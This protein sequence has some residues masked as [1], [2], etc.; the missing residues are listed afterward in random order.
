MDA[1]GGANQKR[2]FWSRIAPAITLMV[3]APLCAEVL[4]GATRFSSIFVF[5]IE[6]LVWGGGAVMIR[7]LVRANRLGWPSMVMLALCLALAEEFL[8]Q[9]TSVAPLVISIK[10]VAWA[11]AWGINY[12]YLLWALVYEAVLV[13]LLPVMLVEMLF[14]SRRHAR[15]LNA[16]GWGLQ[17]VLFAAGSFLAWFSWTQIART[18]VFHLPPY[19][20]PLSHVVLA[21]AAIALLMAASLG[22]WARHWV[23]SPRAGRP[24]APLLF[25][26]GG[27]VWA[28]LWFGL[29]VLAF[30]IMPQLP[31]AAAIGPALA[32][33]A[34]MATTLPLWSAHP[35]WSDAHRGWLIAGTMIATMAI[36]F[37]GGFDP[38]T[39]PA[40]FWFKL[41][42]DAIAGVLFVLLAVRV[43]R[44]A[45]A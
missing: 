33:C 20:P 27:A 32:L 1:V 25:A 45:G 3:M 5:P 6:M 15:W 11:R 17:L 19:T 13:V 41:V 2:G 16:V 28:V 37:L 21:M 43:S 44:R 18:K 35:D 23:E 8:I 34:A 9:Q 22:P 40:D 4:P 29:E 10:G 36:F 31:P 7:E 26:A 12:A 30:G 24:P 38:V 39:G 14:P 42:T